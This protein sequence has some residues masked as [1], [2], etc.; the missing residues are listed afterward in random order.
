M[1]TPSSKVSV[2][3]EN[4]LIVIEKELCPCEIEF[5]TCKTSKAILEWAEYLRNN[6]IDENVCI[7]FL[8]VAISLLE[9]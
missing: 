9:T 2:D 1:T 3:Y 5:E 8:R 6:W 4:K 7:D